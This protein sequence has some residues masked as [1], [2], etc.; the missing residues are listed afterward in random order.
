MRGRKSVPFGQRGFALSRALGEQ[1][2]EALGVGHR[3]LEGIE[4]VGWGEPGQA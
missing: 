2:L 4:R 1:V 3:I